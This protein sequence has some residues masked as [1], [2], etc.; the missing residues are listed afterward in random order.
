MALLG[1]GEL[2]RSF[3]NRGR[4]QELIVDDLHY[5]SYSERTLQAISGPKVAD[6]PQGLTTYLWFVFCGTKDDRVA[7][8]DLVVLPFGQFL[9]PPP[10]VDEGTERRVVVQDDLRMMKVMMCLAAH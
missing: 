6:K 10:P 8:L 5:H 4:C 1:H 3:C 7:M 2:G 9:A